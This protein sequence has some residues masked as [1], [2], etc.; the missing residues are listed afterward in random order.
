MRKIEERERVH[1]AQPWKAKRDFARQR[2]FHRVSYL[3]KALLP[4]NRE[5]ASFGRIAE[6]HQ[7][8]GNT[9]GPLTRV[10]SLSILLIEK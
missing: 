7:S 9:L 2:L 8:R 1:F 3:R 5:A 10:N 4:F 6:F